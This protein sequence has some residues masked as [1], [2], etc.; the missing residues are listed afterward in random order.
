MA[1]LQGGCA[2]LGD[3]AGPAS[4]G[5]IGRPAP[6]FKA[7]SSANAQNSDWSGRSGASG[8]PQ[9]KAEAIETS[10]ANFSRCVAGLYP[11]A[12]ARGVSRARFDA[13]TRDLTP[14][15]KIM[16]LMDAQPEFSKPVWDYVDVLVSEDRIRHGREILSQHRAV[17][18]AVEQQYGVDRYVLA[19]IWGIESKYSTMAGN[20]PVLRSTATLACIGRRQDYFRN[21]FLA[22]LELAARGDVREEQFKGS[23]AGA[24]GPTQ[25][26]PTVYLNHAV[27][28]DG[29][30]RRDM[31]NSVPD[32]LA[33][34]ANFF[35]RNG[36]EKGHAWGYEVAL[37][38]NFD[39]LLADRS[40]QLT[41]SE[42]QRL[43]L[44]RANGQ[45]FADPA[46]QAYLYVPAGAKGPAFLMLHNFRVIM[47]YNPAEAYALAIGH[48]SDR[49]RGGGPFVQNWPRQHRALSLSER[50]ELQQHLARRG[51]DAGEPDGRFGAKTRIALRQYQAS[52]GMVPDGFATASLLDQLRGQ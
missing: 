34:T 44:R 47:R 41:I 16:D 6:V 37:P 51:Y 30:G 26:M 14:D 5:S 20:R 35:R 12:A 50:A 18:D 31:I 38:K 23:W 25:F 11:D 36:W 43:G 33:S 10:A 24:F 29:D 28:A 2:Q 13:L 52:A 49:L 27:D 48:L 39:Y 19:A 40:R 9:M 8:H 42:W 7:S 15:L 4:V 46:A 32:M 22:A 45:H 3:R 21:E 1:L 17:F